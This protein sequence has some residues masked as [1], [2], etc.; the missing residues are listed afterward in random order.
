[1]YNEHGLDKTL[2]STNVAFVD[3][4]SMLQY[5]SRPVLVAMCHD[6]VYCTLFQD[7]DRI[8]SDINMLFMRVTV[9]HTHYPQNVRNLCSYV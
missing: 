5:V 8:G 9:E 4:K 3:I 6:Y 2:R 7:N 1:M